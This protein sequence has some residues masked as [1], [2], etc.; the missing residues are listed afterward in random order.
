MKRISFAKNIAILVNIYW[1]AYNTYF[2]WNFKPESDLEITFDR[3]Y[4]LILYIAIAIY[5]LPMLDKYEKWIK[6]DK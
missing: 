6:E 5:F 4:I 2:G 1:I 3:I